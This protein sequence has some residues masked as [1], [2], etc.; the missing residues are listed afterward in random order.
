MSR[1]A[2]APHSRLAAVALFFALGGGAYAAVVIT[3]KNVRDGSLTGK[4]VKDGSLGLEDFDR[5]DIRGPRGDAGPAGPAGPAG[6]AGP[7]GPAGAPGSAGLGGLPVPEP[8]GPVITK[9]MVTIDGHTLGEFGELVSLRLSS[10]PAFTLRRAQTTN[11][12]MA[13][14]SKLVTDGDLAAAKKSF[15]IT[16]VDALGD[17]KWRWHV[18]A[19]YPNSVTV[20]HGDAGDLIETVAFVADS[21]QRVPI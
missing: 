3:G 12:E 10:S 21:I 1:H 6:V 13:A 8:D 2:Q 14:W 18:V 15:S 4:D 11:I 20:T 17:P 16:A 19:G 9:L 5:D 7:A